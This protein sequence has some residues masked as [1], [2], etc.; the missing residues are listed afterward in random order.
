MYLTRTRLAAFT[1][2]E[3]GLESRA[4]HGRPPTP[5]R[6]AAAFL[7]QRS[8]LEFH[9]VVGL[10]EASSMATTAATIA[11]A[12]PRGRGKYAILVSTRTRARVHRG[13]AP[14]EPSRFK[15]SLGPAQRILLPVQYCT[16]QVVLLQ[17]AAD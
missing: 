13:R 10:H 4:H 7:A 1:R 16:V 3:A 8:L 11:A 9:T 15:S 17:A 12:H 5:S 14:T 2:A 6:I